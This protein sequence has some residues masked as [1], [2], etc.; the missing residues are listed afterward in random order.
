VIDEVLAVL[1]TM[2]KRMGVAWPRE[3]E[4]AILMVL[5]VELETPSILCWG[6]SVIH[7]TILDRTFAAGDLQSKL[8]PQSRDEQRSPFT[9]NPPGAW[10]STGSGDVQLM[11]KS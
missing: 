8:V 9:P 2:G 1:R 4:D 3:V 11:L 7:N 6:F 5:P 10:A